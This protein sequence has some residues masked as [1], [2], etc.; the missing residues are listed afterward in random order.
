GSV[1]YNF[2][3]GDCAQSERRVYLMPTQEERLSTLEQAQ[4][5]FGE[6]VSDLNHHVTMLIGITGRQEWDIREMKT[7]L[8]SVD[9]RLGPLEQSIHT[10]DTKLDQLEALLSQILA[11]L[12][13]KP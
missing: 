11:R 2:A 6:A 9:N 3:Y 7:S 10:Q 4:I 5:R 13:E 8:K 12:P 1:C